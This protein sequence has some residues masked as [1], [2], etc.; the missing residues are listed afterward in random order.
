MSPHRIHHDAPKK[1]YNFHQS[2]D[3]DG[4]SDAKSYQFLYLTDDDTSEQSNDT[5]K[6]SGRDDLSLPTTDISLD[7]SEVTLPDLHPMGAPPTAPAP[8]YG[9]FQSHAAQSKQ[10]LPTNDKF[11]GDQLQLPKPPNI[12]RMATKNFNVVSVNK[13]DDQVT[14][15][16]LD[17]K[18]T[19]VD[20][21]GI[22]EHTVDTGK[23]HVRQSFQK[24]ANK[25]FQ[26]R[27]KI[28]LGSSAYTFVTD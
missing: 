23:Y 11:H 10:L 6:D 9:L 21:Q 27:V 2:E 25:V 7:Q 17:Q 3:P 22:I 20:I 12:F 24:A 16:C 15:L 14:L 13:I 1:A 19:E 26:N 8:Y 5:Y 28:E 4:S 18:K